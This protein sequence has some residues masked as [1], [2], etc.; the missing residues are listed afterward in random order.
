MERTHK[1]EQKND[2]SKPTFDDTRPRS[3][4]PRRKESGGSGDDSESGDYVTHSLS[5]DEQRAADLQ[6]IAELGAMRPDRVTVYLR[7][8]DD[9]NTDEERAEYI[10][11]LMPAQRAGQI[12]GQ[13]PAEMAADI[14]QQIDEERAADILFHVHD[15]VPAEMRSDTAPV[16]LPNT[17]EKARAILDLISNQRAADFLRL[18]SD[19]RAATCLCPMDAQRA[20]DILGRMPDQKAADIQ[21]QMLRDQRAAATPHHVPP[22]DFFQPGEAFGRDTFEE[23]SDEDPDSVDHPYGHSSL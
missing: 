7:Q 2:S 11:G 4:S 10:L 17:E 9:F 14:L 18:C 21:H 3:R 13:L 8:M 6:D 16:Y 19:H 5:S 23:L 12:L 22:E 20:A 15:Y 1:T